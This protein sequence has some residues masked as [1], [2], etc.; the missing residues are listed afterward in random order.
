M[1]K[2][3]AIN[4]VIEEAAKEVC[5]ALLNKGFILQ[6]Y[7]AYST[8]SVYIKL[9]YGVSNSIRVADHTGNK[10]LQYRFNL[11][12]D[13]TSHY[14]DESGKYP[15]EYFPIADIQQLLMAVELHRNAKITQYGLVR[16]QGYMET[17]RQKHLADKTGFW[18]HARR[19]GLNQ[20]GELRYFKTE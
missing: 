1:G 9:D 7:K 4:P 2:R 18:S 13:V 6:L 17:E 20:Q 16:Y 8:S 19:I 12:A 5:V 15:R 10:H 14:L 3:K 11:M